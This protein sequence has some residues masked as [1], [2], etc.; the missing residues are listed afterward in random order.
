MQLP[1][2]CNVEWIPSYSHGL[3]AVL[4]GGDGDYLKY[5]TILI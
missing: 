1:D 3:E 4:W 5:S 2:I